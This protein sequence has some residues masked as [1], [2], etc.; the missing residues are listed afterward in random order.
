MESELDHKFMQ[1]NEE[2]QMS[3]TTGTPMPGES[4]NVTGTEV[5]EES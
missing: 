5:M 4:Q 2:K 3:E 1:N